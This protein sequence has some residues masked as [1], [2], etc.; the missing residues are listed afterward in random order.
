MKS[1]A[2]FENNTESQ[3][4]MKK[5]KSKAR[6][7]RILLVYFENKQRVLKYGKIIEI[8]LNFFEMSRQNQIT[9]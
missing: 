6:M 7:Y 3:C 8:S 9:L 4:K 1:E 2:A 5:L